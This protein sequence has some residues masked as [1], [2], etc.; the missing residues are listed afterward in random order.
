[1]TDQDVAGRPEAGVEP[2]HSDRARLVAG[3]CAGLVLCAVVGAL[4][5]Y[6]LAGDGG[7]QP[8]PTAGPVTTATA[9]EAPRTSRPGPTKTQA[10]RPPTTPP[11]DGMELPDL[12]G[13][14]FDE[15]R[16]ELREKGLGVH[17]IFGDAGNDPSVTRTVPPGGSLVRRGITV[18]VY[19]K[20]A[21]PP[22]TVPDLVGESCREAARELVDEGLYPS[23][24]T[25]DTGTVR[26][27]DPSP[28]STVHWN[29]RVRLYCG[30]GAQPTTVPT[31]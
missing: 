9:P 2:G 27:Q 21:A 13:K 15:A 12:V 26:Q 5:G 17:L 30:T 1:M 23:Y 31:P 16:E 11:I 25:G 8:E 22:V 7:E 20:G 10:K 18:K 3:G 19:V 14:D 28:G 29:D 6:L 24:P 4:G